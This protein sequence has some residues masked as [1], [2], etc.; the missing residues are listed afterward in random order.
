MSEWVTSELRLTNGQG[1][2]GRSQGDTMRVIM[3]SWVELS[4]A[5]DGFCAQGRLLEITLCICFLM[6]IK[7]KSDGDS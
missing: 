1:S 4:D 5:L 7:F 3:G 6:R 2:P